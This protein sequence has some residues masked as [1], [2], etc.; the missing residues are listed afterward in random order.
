VVKHVAWAATLLHRK[1]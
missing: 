1:S